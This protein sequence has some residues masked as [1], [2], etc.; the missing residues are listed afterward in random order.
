MRLAVQTYSVEV[1]RNESYDH[2]RTLAEIT[3]NPVEL[4]VAEKS[5]C[6]S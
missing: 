6:R 5:G 3:K 1:K 2:R 4:S